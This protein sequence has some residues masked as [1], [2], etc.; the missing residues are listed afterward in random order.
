MERF[1]NPVL[2]FAKEINPFEKKE[3][4]KHAVQTQRRFFVI[5]FLNFQMPNVETR[6][7]CR[8]DNPL[9]LDATIVLLY[10]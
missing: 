4:R 3:W 8:H 2:C 7:N 9:V 5:L 1:F 6:S 10:V